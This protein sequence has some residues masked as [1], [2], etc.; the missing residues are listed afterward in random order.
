VNKDAVE[1]P[2]EAQRAHI[3]LDV[4]DLGILLLALSQ[5]RVRDVGQR[6]REIPLEEPGDVAAAAAQLEYGA[7]VLGPEEPAEESGFVRVVFGR[8][9]QLPPAG[10]LGVQF[11]V[12]GTHST[13]LPL[14]RSNL[15]A[16]ILQLGCCL[17]T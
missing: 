7:G 3:A 16:K 12:P 13:T 14:R 11:R 5:H 17:R 4:F 6:Q 9:D 10:Q 1:R 2:A 8:R 15:R